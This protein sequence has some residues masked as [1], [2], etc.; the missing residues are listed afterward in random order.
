MKMIL[1][2]ENKEDEKRVQRVYRLLQLN[3]IEIS[4]KRNKVKNILKSIE[5]KRK[6]VKKIS[7]PSREERNARFLNEVF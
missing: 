7:I 5:P 4:D 6:R 2:I 3:E 1:E